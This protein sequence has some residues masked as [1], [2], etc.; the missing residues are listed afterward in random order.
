MRQEPT[1]HLVCTRCSIQFEHVGRGRCNYCPECRRVVSAERSHAHAVKV[2]RIKNPGVGSGGVQFGEQ[3]TQ[4]KDGRVAYRRLARL[5]GC[6][7]A[8]CGKVDLPKL[9][10]AHHVDRDRSNNAPSN[11][12]LV[13][14]AC[15]QNLEHPIPRDD[16]GRYSAES[17][18]RNEARNPG[19]GQL[20]PKADL[21]G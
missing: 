4:W 11:L 13:C 12:V 16:L 3:N 21:N 15:H 20:E 2:G 6:V 5:A 8:R 7:C 1:R 14:K 17:K 9:M 18:S 19:D 10:C